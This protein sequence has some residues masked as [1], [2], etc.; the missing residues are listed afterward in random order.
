MTTADKTRAIVLKAIRYGDNSLIIKLLTEQ[1]GLQSFIVKGAFNKNA[2]I[3]AALFQPLTLLN[4]V[5]A[6]S[7]GELGYLKE[8]MVEYAYQDIPININKNAIVLFICELLSKSIRETE[9]DIELF[10]FIHNALIHLDEMSDNYADFSLRFSMELTRFIGFAPNINSFK[11]GFI[12][13]LEEGGFRHDSANIS[14]FIDSQLSSSFY[15][16]CCNDVFDDTHL[17]LTNSQRRQLLEAVI[18]YYKLHV[19][20]F[21]EMKSADVLKAVL[22]P[23][24]EAR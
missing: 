3:R 19:S 23:V 18:T 14:Y 20:G 4:I 11:P 21:N 12:F 7:R 8:T 16:L 2:K 22:Q 5:S 6:N 1:N 15:Q 17:N 13:D 10:N 24:S 9:T